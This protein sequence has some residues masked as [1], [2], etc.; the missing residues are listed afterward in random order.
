MLD[1]LVFTGAIDNDV[2]ANGIFT[3]QQ[4]NGLAFEIL[5]EHA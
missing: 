2:F 3:D 1:A 4:M 5:F